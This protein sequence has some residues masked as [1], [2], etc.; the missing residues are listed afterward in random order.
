MNNINTL[1]SKFILQAKEG[2][3]KT[4]E[5]PKEYL[6]LKMKNLIIPSITLHD[7]SEMDGFVID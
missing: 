1:L 6:D 4:A 2:S 7:Y 5:Y 3:L